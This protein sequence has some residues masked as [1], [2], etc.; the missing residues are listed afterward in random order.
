MSDCQ[1]SAYLGALTVRG[2]INI[3]LVLGLFVWGVSNADARSCRFDGAARIELD[4]E[5][6][7]HVPIVYAECK[8]GDG[9][10]LLIFPIRTNLPMS[11]QRPY[12][13]GLPAIDLRSDGLLIQYLKG[14]RA[15]TSAVVEFSPTGKRDEFKL[16]LSSGGEGTYRLSK[17]LAAEL[18]HTDFHLLFDAS[19]EQLSES[20]PGKN[21]QTQ[22]DLLWRE[23]FMSSRKVK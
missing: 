9:K 22:M 14:S 8:Q 23:P 12:A 7:Y 18:S 13:N 19:V 2:I 10:S 21:C 11:V 17:A 6:E 16:D 4:Q 20:M 15:P 1:V 3:T 5:Q